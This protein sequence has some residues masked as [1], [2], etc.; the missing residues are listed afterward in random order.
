MSEIAWL[1]AVELA[2][3]YR[4]HDL[5]PVTVVEHLI[6]RIDHVD[7]LPWIGKI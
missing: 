3:A 4:D 5:S 1:S 2:K 6:E 7:Q